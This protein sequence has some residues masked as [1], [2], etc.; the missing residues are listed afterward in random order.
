VHRAIREAGL[1]LAVGICLG[2]VAPRPQAFEVAA[3]KAHDG[4]LNAMYTFSS[5][6]PR[7]TYQGYTVAYLIMEAFKLKGYQVS[8]GPSPPDW[9]TSVYYDIFAKAEGDA[10][11]SRDDFR[12]MMKSLLAERF[13]L[14][15]HRE[16]KEMPVYALVVGKN[17]PKFKESAP[18]A[19]F[20]ANHGVNGRLQNLVATKF[21]MDM[22]ADDIGVDRPV[23][24]RTGLRGQYD[25]R[26]EATPEF[27]ITN[28]S[29]PGDISIFDALQD[30]LGLKLQPQKAPVEVFVVDHAEKPSVN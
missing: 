19:G 15:F 30:Q 4:P 25:I 13:H 11:L 9:Y 5:S 6:G 8:I 28:N 14:R 24:D 10:P 12:P 27:R 16:Q 7:A 18:D 2:Q 22:L 29:A 23:V 21:T 17:G 1:V 20:H 3:V 26:L